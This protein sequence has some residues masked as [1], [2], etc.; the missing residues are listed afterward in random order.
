M[1][2]ESLSAPLARRHL[3]LG[4]TAALL[5]QP[6]FAS[7]HPDQLHFNLLA[8]LR[9]LQPEVQAADAAVEAALDSG[10]DVT[11][12]SDHRFVLSQRE[13]ALVDKMWLEPATTLDGLKAKA[14]ALGLLMQ[15]DP[16]EYMPATQASMDFKL[17]WAIVNDILRMA[18]ADGA[19]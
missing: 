5:P 1:A 2:I 11:A 4:A 3:L 15:L 10:G 18:A 6:A 17:S 12:A 19:F 16:E 8:Q 9:A 7:A 13:N 14:S